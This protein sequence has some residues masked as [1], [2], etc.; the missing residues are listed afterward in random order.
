[1]E[2]GAGSIEWLSH[3][4]REQCDG[5]WEEE[6]GIR[7]ETLDNPGWLFVVDLKG[8]DLAGKPFAEVKHNYDHAA[9]WWQCRVRDGK[10]E[11]AGGP[12][13]LE[14][15][16]GVFRAWVGASKDGLIK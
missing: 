7:I 12:L 6:H 1:M 9:D 8:T 4:Y 13:H 15:L 16:I 3:W 11:G 5:E 10:F 14:T 2:G